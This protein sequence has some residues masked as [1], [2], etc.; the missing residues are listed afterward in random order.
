MGNNPI[1]YVDPDGEF[2]LGSIFTCIVDFFATAFFKGGLDPTS[3]KA[4]NRAWRNFD[5]S[6]D[7][8]KT[9]K[10]WQIDIGGFKTD[11]NRTVAGRVL[12]FISRWTWEL[13][14]TL[15]GKTVSHTRNITGNVDNVDYYGGAT[16]VNRNDPSAGVRWGFTL[17]PY[18]NSLNVKAD[19]YTDELFRHEFGHTLQSRVVGPLYLTHVGLPSVIGLRLEGVWDH[20]HSREWYET[21][22]NRMAYRYFSNH[23]P[24]ALIFNPITNRGRPWNNTIY[25]RDYNP[26]WYWFFAHPPIPF[27]WWLYF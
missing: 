5:P 4:R 2:F 24:N 3:K 22:A 11:E 19:P 13:P 18:I 26:N 10:A 8:S 23:E 12:Q 14:Q 6:A 21:Q 9:H 1:I 20:D 16:L 25:P 27:L 15:L 7:W 17:G